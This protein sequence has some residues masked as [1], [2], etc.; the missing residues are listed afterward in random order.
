MAYIVFRVRRPFR[1]RIRSGRRRIVWST[2]AAFAAGAGWPD[3]PADQGELRL[4]EAWAKAAARGET[5]D[6]YLG[7]ANSSPATFRVVGMESPVAQAAEF[8][9]SAGERAAGFT[10]EARTVILMEPATSHI[11]LTGLK[12][13]IRSG[14]TI[15]L[16]LRTSTGVRLNVVVTVRDGI[17][18]VA[19][20]PSHSRRKES[21]T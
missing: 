21:E 13:S 4:T 11:R 20:W 15:T 8:V 7:F 6:V 1:G 17:K 9:T 14:Q 18:R 12:E 19:E 2:V 16:R 10:V 5:T 3:V